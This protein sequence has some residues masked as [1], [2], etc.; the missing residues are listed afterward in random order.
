LKFHAGPL[1]ELAREGKQ[2]NRRKPLLVGPATVAPPVAQA[3]TLIE[4]SRLYGPDFMIEIDA[5]AAA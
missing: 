5:A 1:V 3:V 2:A 4:V